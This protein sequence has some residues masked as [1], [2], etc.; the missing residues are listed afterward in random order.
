M[1]KVGIEAISIYFPKIYLPIEELALARNI[2]PE[3]LTKGLG[4]ERMSFLDVHQDVVCMA[5]NALWELFETH[6]ISPKDIHRLYVGTECAVDSSKPIATYL[7]E[8][9]EEKLISGYGKDALS[10]CDCVDLTFA[11]IGG[12]DA[13]QN[14]LDFIRLNPDKK[15]I[16]VC[17][18]FAKYDLGSGGEYTQGAGAVALLISSNPKI[19]SFGNDFAVSTQG[20]FDFFKPRRYLSKTDIKCTEEL[21]VEEEEVMIYKDQP[22]FDGQYSNICYTQRIK[23]AYQRLKEVKGISSPLY[24]TWRGIF[25]HLP[26]A[27]Q[28]RR[29]FT[30]VVAM[31]KGW[32]KQAEDYKEQLKQLNKS[33]EYQQLVKEKIH[34]SEI[35]SAKIGNIYTGSIFLGLLSGLSYWALENMQVAGETIGFIAYGSGSKSKVFEGAIES[36]WKQMVEKA[37][38]F[39][40]LEQTTPISFDEYLQLYRKK[41]KASK[42][43]PK[44]E[45]VLDRI[46]NE[47]PNLLG[48]RYYRW[49]E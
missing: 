17:T 16:V 43:P 27:F 35:A 38:L 44:K 37:A 49:V 9:M 31:E 32:E 21:G 39:S 15:A 36:G 13:L 47:H 22:V 20:V 46:E 5:A 34:P 10:H 40:K 48:A 6:E 41:M 11:C 33:D 12:V 8:L 29:M 42:I 7:L 45:F 1:Q 25:L 3:K 28:A 24:E 30:E 4:L 23:Q 18:D 19:I 14:C 26:Y 2:E